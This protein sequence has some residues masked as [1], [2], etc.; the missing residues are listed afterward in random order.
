VNSA[1]S[2]EHPVRDRAGRARHYWA[3]TVV[4]ALDS[5]AA[6][7]R[8]GVKETACSEGRSVNRGGPTAP[9]REVDSGG[10]NARYK[11]KAKAGKVR[12]ESER[13]IVA[14]IAETTE[15]GVAKVPHFGDARVARDGRGHG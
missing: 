1:A 15:L 14:R 7:N 2:K 5:G 11:P 3:K 4:R 8:S 10:S 13:D 9:V 6:W 12:R